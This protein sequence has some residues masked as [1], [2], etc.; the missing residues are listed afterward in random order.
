M[1]M[2]VS[3][4][5]P[6]SSPRPVQMSHAF[7]LCKQG[8]QPAASQFDFSSQHL[9][10]LAPLHATVANLSTGAR[11]IRFLRLFGQTRCYLLTPGGTPDETAQYVNRILGE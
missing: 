10:L 9:P 2:P 11:T 8:R 5:F 7:F 3:E 4:L 1:R 6:A